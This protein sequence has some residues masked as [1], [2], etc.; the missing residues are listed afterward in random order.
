MRNSRT[1]KVNSYLKLCLA[2]CGQSLQHFWDVGYFY[3]FM[4]SLISTLA[5]SLGY[6][7]AIFYLLMVRILGTLFWLCLLTLFTFFPG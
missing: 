6:L 1:Y 4:K 2:K 7:F 3:I 5:A